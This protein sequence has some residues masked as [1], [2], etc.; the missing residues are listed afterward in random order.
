MYKTK[1]AITL[2]EGTLNRLDGLVKDR[3][4]PNRSKAIY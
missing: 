3:I 2:D 1:V 4:F